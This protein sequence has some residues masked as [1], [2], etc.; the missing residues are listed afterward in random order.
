MGLRACGV[1]E[2]PDFDRVGVHHFV[3][4]VGVEK[5]AVERVNHAG[6]RHAAVRHHV[7][8]VE[9]ARGYGFRFSDFFDGH[10]RSGQYERVVFL[11]CDLEFQDSE[12]LF[13]LRRR[14]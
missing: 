7:S 3:A 14:A 4:A 10:Q 9:R 13:A 11:S 1:V 8:D 12:R 6:H 2:F 5:F